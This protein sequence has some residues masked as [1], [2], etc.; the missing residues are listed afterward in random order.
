MK[1]FIAV[2]LTTIT[3]LLTLFVMCTFGNTLV[4][5]GFV[6]AVYVFACLLVPV[7]AAFGVIYILTYSDNQRLKAN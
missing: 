1:D 7:L 3:F 6:A 2:L 4:I 5:T